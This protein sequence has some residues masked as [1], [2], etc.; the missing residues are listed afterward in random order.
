M[1]YLVTMTT[2]VPDGT[3]DEAVQDIRTREAAHSRQLAGQGH[4]LR[5]WRPPLR[6]G[7]WRTLGLFAAEDSSELEEVL[8]SMPLR[9]WRRDEV[10]PLSP[11]P[12]D[13][14]PHATGAATRTGDAP[15]SEFLTTFTVAVPAGTAPATVDTLSRREADRARELAGQGYLERL[16]T[17]PGDGRALGL[18]R[19]PDATGMDAILT[20]LPLSPWMSVQTTPLTPHPSDPALA[21]S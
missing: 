8:A 15:A 2:H 21:A 19:C 3:P 4:L 14:A 5:L 7:E 11:H 13:P 6:P 12:N 18:W 10:T 9:V 20:S 1:E 16:W 17:L